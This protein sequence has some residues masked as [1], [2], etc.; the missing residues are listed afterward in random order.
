MEE[1]NNLQYLSD[2]L[3]KLTNPEKSNSNMVFEDME[4]TEI[5]EEAQKKVANLAKQKNI[6]IINH[7]KKA[8]ISGDRQSLTELFVIILDNAIKYSPK[9]TAVTIN[10]AFLDNHI[11]IHIKDEGPGIDKKDLPH[12]FDR[13]Y[14]A[15]ISRTSKEVHGYGLGLSI[16]RQIVNKHHGQIK[17]ASEVG[18]GSVFSIQLPVKQK[19][20]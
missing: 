11:V 15:D 9:N 1:V 19:G 2:N 7:L 16:A 8:I 12:L 4:L 14:R 6:K 18:K 20:S 5:L 10:S 17:V 13:F 3:I